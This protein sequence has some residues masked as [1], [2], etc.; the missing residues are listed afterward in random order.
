MIKFEIEGVKGKGRP[1]FDSRGHAYTPDTTRAYEEL[2]RLRYRQATKQ[3]PTSSAVY[4]EVVAWLVPAESLS[5]KKRLE[6]L[7]N[8]PMKKPDIDNIA[9]I[10]LD[11]LNG[12]AWVDDKQVV[13]L[14]ICKLWGHSEK[15]SVFIVTEEEINERCKL[16]RSID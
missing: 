8:P 14:N 11:A 5:K 13:K 10:I 6:L 1:R 3:P 7:E 15:I 16:N 9:K 4:V 12:V 2:V